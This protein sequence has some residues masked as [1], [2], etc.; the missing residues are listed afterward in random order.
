MASCLTT[1]KLG[2]VMCNDTSKGKYQ[3]WWMLIELTV[4]EFS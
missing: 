3:I 2:A 1:T 4:L